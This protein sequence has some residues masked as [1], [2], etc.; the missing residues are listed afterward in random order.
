MCFLFAF[1][2]IAAWSWALLVVV[3]LYLPEDPQLVCLPHNDA[4]M[5][6]EYRVAQG[7]YPVAQL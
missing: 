7:E 1:S 4:E 6:L 5:C 2:D 3:R